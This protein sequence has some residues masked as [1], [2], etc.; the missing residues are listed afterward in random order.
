M[1]QDIVAFSVIS[2]VTG[3]ALSSTS[4]MEVLLRN[5]GPT[6]VV[7]NI[8]VSYQINNGP[9]I[10]EPT[11]S[12]STVGAFV[13]YSFATTANL[14]SPG[15]YTITFYTNH[16]GELDTS[17]DTIRSTIVNYAPTIAGTTNGSMAVCSSGNNGAIS[18]SG[19]LGE[20]IRWEQSANQSTWSNIT[21]T[22][23]L[24][25]Y[26]NLAATTYYRAVVKNGTCLQQTSSITTITVDQAPVGGSLA[27]SNIFCFTPNNGSITLSGQ[28]GTISSW[29]SSQDGGSSWTGIANTSTIQSY[30]NLTQTTIF[31]ALTSRG[32]CTIAQS[33]IATITIHPLSV[34]GSVT[35]ET[36]CI[37]GNSGT[38]DL[39]GNIGNIVNWQFSTD[40][41]TSWT[42]VSSTSANLPYSN[43]LQQTMYRANIKS[44][45][46]IATFSAAG[47]LSIDALPVP[48][49][50]SST[51]SKVC[52][53]LNE[54]A[55][56]LAGQVGTIQKWE[57]SIDNS[58]YTT[59]ANTS[60][61]LPFN[62]IAATTQYR[63][64]IANGTCPVTYTNVVEITTDAQS[65]G[66]K[67]TGDSIIC[68]KFNEGKIALI[69]YVG[70]IVNW[71][72]STDNLNFSEIL[73]VANFIDYKNIEST[74]YYRANVKSG[75]CAIAKSPVFT[76]STTG[77]P[78]IELTQ[79]TVIDVGDEAQ[80]TAA[81]GVKYLWAYNESLSDST[82]FNPIAKPTQ[83]TT[84]Y[85]TVE[86]GKLCQNK[87][88][89]IVTVEF[90]YK[91]KIAN[92]FTPNGDGYN[93]FWM[94]K[95]LENYPNN[96]VYIHNRNGQEVFHTKAYQNNWDGSTN[97]NK[98]PDG[99]YF[100]TL[101]FSDNDK[102]FRGSIT[103][104]RGE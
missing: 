75:V 54:G 51:S 84:Y 30:T 7:G 5:N 68:P 76:L 73:S 49:S 96:E 11:S 3:C 99:A 78:K 103:I 57:S 48:G 83:T 92:L 40:G 2:P 36:A 77:G 61:N 89:V 101:K 38:M 9:I 80:L 47:T 104:L 1:A 87:D 97:G 14:S 33:T 67:I 72:S 4:T 58:N 22:T 42:N 27:G 50:I 63:A 94:I 90:N 26:N 17:N 52:A 12:V 20:V 23:T 44:G 62:N 6:P 79:D 69:S 53:N 41:G 34:G 29:E 39:S 35:S 81:G 46:C 24:Q 98:L 8:N 55:I 45:T 88:S 65:K 82:I 86:D 25:T 70:D 13:A 71:E 93:D 85:L 74:T 66:G 91:F 59:I 21:N 100:Y 18:L 10:T 95:N 16:P 43:V 15:T 102:L 64:V 28:S 19:N 32:V 31:K 60:T 56:V 37:A